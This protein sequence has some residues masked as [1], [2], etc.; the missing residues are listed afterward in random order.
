MIL[1][2]E[3]RAQLKLEVDKRRRRKTRTPLP[4]QPRGYCEAI[5]EAHFKC[6]NLAQAGRIYC[7]LHQRM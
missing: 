7:G 6:K 5:T 4:G 1:T 2:A 3:Q